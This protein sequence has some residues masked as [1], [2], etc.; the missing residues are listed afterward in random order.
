V[1][2]VYKRENTAMK[3][4]RVTAELAGFSGK[5]KLL[6]GLIAAGSFAAL[7]IVTNVLWPSM[8]SG[9][10]L[11]NVVGALVSS[12]IFAF[13]LGVITQRNLN[14]KVLV[15][16]DCI[17]AVRPGWERS[18]RDTE[19]RTVAESD[20]NVLIAPSLRIS[21][22]GRFGTWFWGGIWIPRA[23]PEYEQVRNLALSW[24]DRA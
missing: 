4:Y 18:I 15:S 12:A 14:Y 6:R 11:E 20:G 22:H 10:V 17:T 21:K 5:R 3:T 16:D 13:A 7:G 23:L 2:K 8:S 24:K 1:P 19:V 9:H